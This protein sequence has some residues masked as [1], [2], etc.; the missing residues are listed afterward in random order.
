MWRKWKLV[1]A[2]VIGGLALAA[3][4]LF[5]SGVADVASQAVE[6]Q[7]KTFGQAIYEYHT[8]TG[9]WPQD[10]EDLNRTSLP[11]RLRYW[12]ATLDNGSIVIVWHKNLHSDPA[13]NAG[14]VLVYHNRGLLAEMGHQWVCW[15]DLRNEYISS[16]KLKQTLAAEAQ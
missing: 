8:I 13:A 7:L 9:N 4:V 1:A 11:L 3:V 10:A 16:R 2:L 15:G 12:R 14:V 6:Y 5:Y